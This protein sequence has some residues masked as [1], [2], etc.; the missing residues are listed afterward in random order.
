MNFDDVKQQ[1]E[2][3]PAF[4]DTDRERILAAMKRAYEGSSIF[5]KMVDDWL[6]ANPTKKIEFYFDPVP[7][8]VPNSGQVDFSFTA[9]IPTSY[10]DNFGKAVKT[11]DDMAIVH[12]LVHALKPLTDDLTAIEYRG[13]TVKFANT[14]YKQLYIPE[15]N[16]YRAHSAVLIPDFQY[17]NGAAI[18]KSIAGNNANLNSAPA[19]NS[20][21]L[22][23]GGASDNMLIAGDGR[24]YLYGN[25]GD[26]TLDGGADNDLLVGGTG[27]DTYTFTGAFG[28]DTILDSD[29][30]GTLRIDTL[31]PAAGKKIGDN[32]WQS[33]DKK[34]RYSLNDRDELLISQAG[35]ANHITVKG[36]SVMGGN[37][38]GID[39]QGAATP[40][41]STTQTYTGD[42]RP[43]IIGAGN[44]TQLTVTSDKPAYGTY[45]WGET[46][47]ATDGTLNNGLPQ[48]NFADVITGT[49]ANDK[50]NGLGGNDA[51][52][53]GAGNDVIDGGIGD[54][55][56]GGG[57]GSDTI[58]GGAG[59]DYIASSATLNVA[60]RNKPTDSWSPPAGQPILT[61][62]PGWG[63]FIDIRDGQP[64]AIW[65]GANTPS[66]TEA[67]VIDGGAGND[68]IIASGGNDRVQGGLDDDDLSGMAGDD[69]LE[70]NDG[71]D[72][73]NGDG[74]IKPGYLN[75]IAAQYHGADFIDGGA[76]DDKLTGGGGNDDIYGGADND[77]LYGDSGGNTGNADYVNLAY[78]GNDYLDGEGGDDY[79]EGGGKDDTLYGG[80]GK[81]NLWGDTTA[82]N[83]ATPADGALLW[84]NDYLD[85]EDGDDKLIGGGKDDTLYGGTGNDSLWGDESNAALAGSA[86]GNDYLDGEAGDDYL[87]GGGG[88]DTLYGGTDND[89]LKGDDDLSIVAA[90]F[91]GADY[92]DGGDGNDNLSGGGGN[93]T[94]LGGAGNDTLDGGTGADYMAGGA[95]NDTYVI[96]N[97]GDVIVEPD[98]GSTVINTTAAA[99]TATSSAG[100]DKVTA[101]ASTTTSTAPDITNVQA[102]ISYTL[103]NNLDNLELTGTATIDG[104]GNALDNGLFGNSAANVLTGGAGNDYLKGAAGNDTYVFNRGDGQDTIDNTDFLRDTAQPSLLAAVDTLRLG[105]DVA[106]TDVV[107]LRV[108]DNLVLKLNGTTDQITLGNYYGADLV[109]GT[110][111]SDHKIDR[112]EFGNGVVWDQAMIQTQVDKAASNHAP[113]V[114][115]PLPGLQARADHAFTYTVPAGAITDTDAGDT[116]RYSATMQGGAALPVWLSFDPATRTFNGTP[117]AADM[118][119]LQFVLWGTDNYGLATGQVVNLAIGGA[120]NQAPVLAVALPDFSAAPSQAFTYTLPIGAFTDADVGVGVGDA[121][122][123]SATLADGS[124]LPTW[125]SFNAATRTFT[126]TSSTLGSTSVRVT[127]TDMDNLTATDVF[128]VVVQ[129]ASIEGTSANDTLNGT[130]GND[131]LLGLAG[132]DTLYGGGGHDTLDGGTG[133]DRMTG[134]VGSDTYIFNV[135]DGQ[136]SITESAPNVGDVDTLVF[137]PGIALSD[138]T[139]SQSDDGLMFHIGNTLDQVKVAGW[140]RDSN[141]RL[142]SVRF[143]DGTTWDTA[144]LT[145]AANAVR[146][147]G[148]DGDDV[149]TDSGING[150]LRGLGGNDILRG[151]KGN[152][153]LYGGD[154]NDKLY[155]GSGTNTLDG[156]AGDD[157]I[158]DFDG[159][160]SDPISV[161]TIIGGAGN[162]TLYG[163]IYNDT[164]KFNLGDGQ[165][166]IQEVSYYTTYKDKMIFGAGIAPAD[167]VTSR[168]GDNLIF[169]NKNNTDQITV[170]GWFGRADLGEKQIE[171]IEFAD[172]TV[173]TAASLTAPLLSTVGTAGDDV[174]VGTS[175]KDTLNGLDGN[176]TLTGGFDDDML[177]GGNG[178]DVLN[179]G[180]GADQLYGGDGDDTLDGGTGVNVLDGGAGNDTLVVKFDSRLE[181]D[182]RNTLLGGAGNDTIKAYSPLA[183]SNIIEGGTGDDLLNGGA[184]DDSYRFNLGDGKDTIVEV[185][186]ESFTD[187]IVFGTGISPSDLR[188]MHV[189]NDLVIRYS[190]GTDQITIKDWYFNSNARIE[191]VVFNNGTTW[192]PA[193]LEAATLVAT[194]G[195]DVLTG[196]DA[197]DVLYGLG[198]NDTING[199]GG[200]DN[201]YG[202]DGNDILDGGNSANDILDGGNGNDTLSARGNSTLLG[203]AGD[204]VFSTLEAGEGARPIL[205]GGT[206]NDTFS[207][208]IGADTYRFNL[209]DG[210]DT[211]REAE[212]YWYVLPDKLVFGPNILPADIKVTRAGDDVVF[213]HA[214][215][216]DQI[217]VKNWFGAIDRQIESIEFANGTVWTA[218]SLNTS[219]STTNG[220]DGNDLLSGGTGN[221]ILNGL[222]GNDTLYGLEGL[223]T[224]SGGLGDDILDGGLDSDTLAGGAGN[225]TYFVDVSSDVVTELVNE[226]TDTVNATIT[227]TLGANVENLMLGGTEIIDGTGNAL[228]N[229]ISGNAANNKLTGG[230]GD[231]VLDGG[232]GVDTLV[233]G[234]GNDTYIVDTTTD[235]ITEASNQGTDL[236]KASVS[237]TLA[238]N[239]ENLTLTGTANINGTG[240]AAANVITGNSGDNV[241]NGGAGSDTLI[242]GAGS[243]TY[244]VDVSTDVITE[245]AGEGAD[246]VNAS[247]TYTLG[248][249]LENLTLTGTAAINGTGN[250]LANVITGNTGNNIL[251]GG[252][253]NDVYVIG[254]GGG[255][256]TIQEATADATA[257]KLNIL[258]FGTGVN[259]AN[260]VVA[261][262]GSDLVITFT[263]STNKVTVKSFYVNGDSTNTSNPVQRIEFVDGGV[264]WD[265]AAIDQKAGVFVN[266][267]PTVANAITAQSTAE[268]AVWSLVVPANTF[269]DADLA[270]GDALTFTATKSDGT[271]LPSWVTFNATTRTFSGTPLNANVGSQSFKV[272]AKDKAAAA[273]S[274][275]FAVTVTNTNDAPTVAV[276]LTTQAATNGVPWTYVVPANTFADVD[277]GDTLTYSATKADGSALPSWLTFNAGTRT[278]SGTPTPIDAGSLSL[279]VQVKDTAGALVSSTFA[280]TVAGVNTI[281]G[282]AGADTL[283]GT[284]A[285][286]IINGLAGNDTIDGGAGADTLVGGAGNDSYKVDNTGDVVTELANEGT[287]LVTASVSY[288]LSANVENLTLSGTGNINA[289][290]NTAA[291][292]LTGNAGNNVLDGGAGADTLLGG[293]GNDTYY[294]DNTADVTTEASSAGTDLVIAS[295]NWTLAANLENLT[296]AGT[297]NLNGTG[298]TAAN[299]I[300]G[301]AGNNILD[302]GTGN[303][304]LIGGAGNDTYIID[305]ATDTITENANEGTDT[306]KS[307]ATYTLG[308]NLENLTLTGT[309]AINGT[310]NTLNNVLTGNTANNTLTGGAGDDTLDGGT[311]NDTLIGGTGNDTYFLD[312]STDVVTE[313]TN[314]GTDTVNAAFTLTLST[315]LENLTLT[316]TSAI[317]GTGNASANVLTGNS[318]ANTLTGNAGNDT[319]DGKAGADSLIGG[320]GNDTYKLGR[321]YGA[322][323]IT[324]NDATA[325]NTDVAL[326]DTG[327]TT[328]QLWFLKVGNNLEV[329][330]IGTNDKFTLTNWYLG[331]QYHVEQFKTSDG[332]VLLDSQVQALVQAMAAFSP[333]AAGQTT[334]TPSMAATL[335]PVLA[336][337]W[338]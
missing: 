110:K 222:A 200:D 220:T 278:F 2:I 280:V 120:A 163:N 185:N 25:G 191:T 140:Y 259:S 217:T 254:A 53:G 330:I 301:N 84:G 60:P 64:T 70:G 63:V 251:D 156:G 260:A 35:N 221:D 205:E 256:D 195:D 321:G 32:L 94:L 263:G 227:Y 122:T 81:D 119:N 148:T 117:G 104:S 72:T 174:I 247:F 4:L 249:N 299:V 7:G 79:I 176:D 48:A 229:V 80:S 22:L 281:N 20:K 108:G 87:V 198:G 19:G 23:V 279:K 112:V 58:Q 207:G 139:L 116:V 93:D 308:S 37:K 295:V 21:D 99:S 157:E 218:A 291:N 78:H 33:D 10:I 209:G 323:T 46:S 187:K 153:V 86:N 29:G 151:G 310:G 98:K 52:S 34:W 160:F 50:I 293:A 292:T 96:D 304:T 328:D 97:V 115:T 315:N 268:D 194:Q 168:E 314:E 305:V 331:S 235:V 167:I 152:N 214:N 27:N 225:D 312:V 285:A 175:L 306:V 36:W 334:L 183:T 284:A 329:D 286:D 257:G 92:L 178:S 318:G 113:T 1:I 169:R 5:R 197:N 324:E 287:D 258:R 184:N 45:A 111:I 85:G 243:D 132:D 267:A 109:E 252:A 171:T 234:A 155:G 65:S 118:G 43:K 67:D 211:I 40:T 172:G 335:Q 135:G 41:P 47:W 38:L 100:P 270:A 180:I 76:G 101:M 13:D 274:A 239:V 71:K 141:L 69:I 137:G 240:N 298:N 245:L 130:V 333:P 90:E 199:M 253:G 147:Q 30:N 317:N 282:T 133:N 212:G 319:L 31:A 164:Y 297:G 89:T 114:G 83:V 154:G 275:T 203:G 296:L 190:N 11:T 144:T 136:D 44:E 276:A 265:L 28:N 170:R 332:K 255:Q 179:G 57:A 210:Q 264:A 124:A 269:A 6:S 303:D 91:Q 173:W 206:G 223:D 131:T 39:L 327:I 311:G 15:Q 338:H 3:S 150:T 149:I 326:F 181:P 216:T 241:L 238:A 262:S 134:G 325:G 158:R 182:N 125:L 127:A 248:T 272:T 82:S 14:I 294:M 302:G 123:Y 307:G 59:N 16:S 230:A 192:S 215:G 189:G 208:G 277:V 316:G 54:D 74:T 219:L 193:D 129:I 73:I 336:A 313:N 51:L 300:T 322:D 237:L 24:D 162:D 213:R 128:D 224:L 102:S 161:T 8:A 159:S 204:D 9:L 320:K 337:N 62:G 288:T 142:E 61:Q 266:H 232:A 250:A 188:V 26:D 88:A 233:G 177:Y 196:T 42:Q 66:G 77:K 166:S 271:A 56:I 246:N 236:V 309:S 145:T 105:T 18:D 75:T 244:F 103:G 283:T 202:G 231:D 165:D 289:T 138:I 242:G 146:G 226:G 68:N 228:N 143:G 12:E 17:T 273:A 106:D 49:A 186:S 121:L 95:G 261:R 107:A 55:L 290:G 126:G 201:L